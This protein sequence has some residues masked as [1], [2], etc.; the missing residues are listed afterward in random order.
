[1]FIFT[2]V[3]TELLCRR[4]V[5]IDHYVKRRKRVIANAKN[6]GTLGFHDGFEPLLTAGIGVARQLGLEPNK[7]GINLRM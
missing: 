7:F 3:I 5:I 1:M 6:N 2:L 4:I